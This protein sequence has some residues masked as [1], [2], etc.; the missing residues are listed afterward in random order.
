MKQS[1]EKGL[2]ME[3][4]RLFIFCLHRCAGNNRNPT[5]ETVKSDKK[6]Y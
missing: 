4:E 6:K 3:G 1:K 5:H 2:S